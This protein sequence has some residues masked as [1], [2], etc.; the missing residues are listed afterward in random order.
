M[1][2]AAFSWNCFPW[3]DSVQ[4]PSWAGLAVPLCR[5]PLESHLSLPRLAQPGVLS[6]VL[7]AA[8]PALLCLKSDA[9]FCFKML[10]GKGPSSPLCCCDS[11]TPQTPLPVTSSQTLSW[12]VSASV[13]SSH[14][15][16]VLVESCLR[17]P[18]GKLALASLQRQF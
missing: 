18:A 2:R 17:I 7:T 6:P 15:S 4:N 5:A 9:V 12:K 8:E 3:Q 11:H 13:A 1:Q 16:L 10:L 14:L